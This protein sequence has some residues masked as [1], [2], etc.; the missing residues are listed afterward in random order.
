MQMYIVHMGLRLNPLAS[1]VRQKRPVCAGGMRSAPANKKTLFS[2]ICAGVCAP[3]RP[4]DYRLSYALGGMRS[5]P[6]NKK[7]LF[8][9][10]RQLATGRLDVR[11]SPP[12]GRAPLY[13][14]TS[15]SHTSIFHTS[16]PTYLIPPYL[17]HSNLHT[18]YLHTSYSYLPAHELLLYGGVR[19]G[20]M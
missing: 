12:F 20:G 17:S 6:A 5:A 4:M 19:Y 7:T 3:R 18:S 2:L 9:P 11:S 1:L 14:H 8:L 16:I 10:S 15:I 13:L